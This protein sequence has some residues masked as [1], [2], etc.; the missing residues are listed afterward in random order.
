MTTWDN[1][2]DS[3]ISV[4]QIQVTVGQCCVSWSYLSQLLPLNQASGLGGPLD[5]VV[6]CLSS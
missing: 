5:T 1:D 2:M 6:K 3:G 4:V